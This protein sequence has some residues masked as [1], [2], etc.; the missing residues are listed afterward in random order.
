[1]L[2]QLPDAEDKPP[3]VL[4]SSPNIHAVLG[5]GT[6]ADPFSAFTAE[7][8]ADIGKDIT[9]LREEGFFPERT[10][11]LAHSGTIIS[12]SGHMVD[13]ARFLVTMRDVTEKELATAEKEAAIGEKER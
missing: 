9:C 12:C 2:C 10:K 4:R 3:L 13:K 11:T 8:Q 7:Q 6:G 1:M 5:L